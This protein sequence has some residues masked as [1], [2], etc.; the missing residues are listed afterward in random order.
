MG[1]R[2]MKNEAGSRKSGNFNTGL[3]FATSDFILRTS[4]I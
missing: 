2:S 3:Q 4:F 1:L